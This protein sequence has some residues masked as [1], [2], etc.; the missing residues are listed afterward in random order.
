MVSN[1]KR[2]KDVDN[3]CSTCVAEQ[4]EP[5]FL[6]E[7]KGDLAH[8]V[9]SSSC[10]SLASI[11]TAS[12][13]S[14]SNT[15]SQ[16]VSSGRPSPS[17]TVLRL[18]VLSALDAPETQQ[19]D[20]P[21]LKQQQS[22]TQ[23]QEEQL[24]QQP[25]QQ[26]AQQAAQQ[27]LLESQTQSRVEL[28]QW[29]FVVHGNMRMSQETM[30][31]AISMVNRY[32]TRRATVRQFKRNLPR[33]SS[34]VFAA[35]SIVGSAETADRVCQ[36]KP[37]KLIGAAALLAAAKFNHGDKFNGASV[38]REFVFSLGGLYTKDQIVK[39]ELSILKVLD[40]QIWQLPAA[41][42]LQRYVQVN[43]AHMEP[44]KVTEQPA[45]QAQQAQEAVQACNDLARRH[46][47][48]TQ[49]W[50]PTIQ[51]A[52]DYNGVVSAIQRHPFPGDEVLT[53]KGQLLLFRELV[54]LQGDA[55]KDA[56]PI[57]LKLTEARIEQSGDIESDAEKRSVH[58]E[59]LSNLLN[60]LTRISRMLQLRPQTLALAQNIADQ[61]L[62]TQVIAP[63]CLQLLGA[64]ALFVASNVDYGTEFSQNIWR[65]LS[66]I[67]AVA[68][69]TKED[70]AQINFLIHS[71]SD[72]PVLGAH[73]MHRY[74][75]ASGDDLLT[76]PRPSELDTGDDGGV[77]P[78]NLDDREECAAPS[79]AVSSSNDP[80][81]IGTAEAPAALSAPQR[82]SWLTD[83]RIMEA[84]IGLSKAIEA[85]R[86][87]EDERHELE[88]LWRK[89][90]DVETAHR[91]MAEAQDLVQCRREAGQRLGTLD[92][93]VARSYDMLD[94]RLKHLHKIA[95]VV[96]DELFPR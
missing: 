73:L 66:S 20:H 86:A 34:G 53:A 19:T 94:L 35:G 1:D 27:G 33:T 18:E 92:V 85:M 68:S 25:A 69:C 36:A 30:Q 48:Q 67:N 37:L 41:H 61:Y 29:M 15:S 9:H 91:A 88:S 63:R 50:S 32:L 93:D 43:L 44:Q 6:G 2:L 7:L 78:S 52:A 70:V 17:E 8:N 56:F 76:Q 46:D 4:L 87:S 58:A 82:G 22:H 24:A 42:L 10:C 95:G 65:Y 11:A 62:K 74:A 3:G 39:M 72:Y 59:M 5:E 80:K 84:Q 75:E 47:L 14:P 51:F 60:W 21:L 96:L 31:L 64:T 12:T 71:A 57:R 77:A 83:P 16:S 54:S 13:L 90:Q 23:Q 38:V 81:S 40:F 26:P 28:L 79:A 89:L 55:L 45:Q 49:A